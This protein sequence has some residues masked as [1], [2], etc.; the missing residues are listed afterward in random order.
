MSKPELMSHED[1]QKLIQ[2][3]IIIRTIGRSHGWGGVQFT[4][5]LTRHRQSEQYPQASDGVRGYK[6]YQED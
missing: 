3:P 5:A 6:G 1:R 2:A 4:G